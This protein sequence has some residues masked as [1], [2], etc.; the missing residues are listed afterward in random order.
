MRKAAGALRAQ[1]DEEGAKLITDQLAPIT[2][3]EPVPPKPVTKQLEDAAATMRR[4]EYQQ[5]RLRD[6]LQRAAD[7]QAQLEEKLTTNI[8]EHSKKAA[9]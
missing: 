9:D 7:W 1:G 8:E 3:P 2:E 6:Q 4:L 5:E